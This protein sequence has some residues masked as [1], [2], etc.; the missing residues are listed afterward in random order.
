MWEYN[1][2][3][4][5]HHGILGQKW[6][7]RRY[8]NPDGT[9]TDAGKKRYTTS[10]DVSKK[11]SDASK[12]KKRLELQMEKTKSYKKEY[13]QAIKELKKEE[14]KK[15]LAFTDSDRIKMTLLFNSVTA[16]RVDNL[17]NKNA[18][19]TVEEAKKRA[20]GEALIYTL[21]V[22]GATTIATLLT[23]R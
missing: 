14:R 8:Q 5:S 12:L 13:K 19:M 6:G 20:A 9:L 18:N 2:D 16:Q 10:A 4:L 23:N 1:Y 11:R 3:C 22:A 15:N 7:V 21:S 17:L